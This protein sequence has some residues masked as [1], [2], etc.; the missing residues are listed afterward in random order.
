MTHP[1]L[2][3]PGPVEVDPEL[4]EIMAMPAL[5]HRSQTTK[6]CITRMLPMLRAFFCT[7]QHAF[8]E[9]V[10][11]TA[12]MEATI[13]NLV[14]E[15]VLHLACGAFGERWA[16]ISEQCGRRPDCVTLPWG[17]AVTADVA[18]DALRRADRPYEA[19]CITHCETSTGV[20][21]PLGEIAAAVREVAPNTLILADVVTSVGGAEMRFDDWGLDAA[22]AGTQKCLALP[23]GLTVFAL[24]ERAIRKS[25]E[26]AGRGFLLDFADTPARF[27]KA[28]PPATPCVPLVF[29][30]ARQLERIAAE[31]LA[32]RHARHLALR[33]RTLAW[34]QAEGYAPFVADARHR[35]PTVSTLRADAA[36]TNALVAAGKKG[37][38]TLGKGYGKIAGETF[39]VGHMGDHTLQRLDALLAALRGV[40]S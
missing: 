28:E 3:I 8:F 34:A 32:V 20:L 38:F 9:N 19:V 10:P 5:G 7:T 2:F 17:S 22:F 6:D 27:A 1:V 25:A 13:R 37:G 11:A 26:V 23:P 4:R 24:S 12:L 16:K 33:D 18:R 14:H 29:A 36:R 39:R 40:K 31:T 30:L 35:S 15:R 21:S